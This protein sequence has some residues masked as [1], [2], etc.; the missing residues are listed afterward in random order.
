MGDSLDW[1][2]VKGVRDVHHKHDSVIFKWGL[3]IGWNFGHDLSN[4]K[5]HE[6]CNL[7]LQVSL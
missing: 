4:G 3:G 7:E 5:G 2:L 6:V 1:G